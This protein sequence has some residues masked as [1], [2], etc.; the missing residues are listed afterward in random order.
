MRKRIDAQGWAEFN[1]HP[2]LCLTSPAARCHPGRNRWAVLGSLVPTRR[3]G[4]ESGVAKPRTFHSLLVT[5]KHACSHGR[6]SG[7]VWVKSHTAQA[8][9]TWVTWGGRR[10][11]HGASSQ[12]WKMEVSNSQLSL[13]HLGPSPNTVGPKQTWCPQFWI[14][15]PM[16]TLYAPGSEDWESS[17]SLSSL[18][19]L[20][21]LLRGWQCSF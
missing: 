18:P 7:L 4:S 12:V 16:L 19:Q 11:V 3:E 6:P 10:A 20:P 14:Q 9:P 1:Q 21:L 13:S 2:A 8:V 17:I 5:H 15:F